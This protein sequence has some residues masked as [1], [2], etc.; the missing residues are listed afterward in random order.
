MSKAYADV[1]TAEELVEY[2]LNY[3]AAHPK[4]RNDRWFIIPDTYLDTRHIQIEDVMTSLIP[5]AERQGLRATFGHL[6]HGF[7]PVGFDEPIFVIFLDPQKRSN[8]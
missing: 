7:G 4:T 1:E 5:L 2:F 8:R 6:P 3:I